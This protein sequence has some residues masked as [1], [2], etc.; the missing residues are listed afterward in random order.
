MKIKYIFGYIKIAYILICTILLFSISYKVSAQGLLFQANDKLISERTSYNVFNSSTPVFNN[1]FTLSFELSI[2]DST[3]FGYICFIKDKESDASFSLTLAETDRDVFLDFNID[4]KQNLLRVPIKKTDLGYRRW[5]LVII[6]F[7]SDK[8]TIEIKFDDK[9][10][11]SHFKQYKNRFS[12]VI[13]F[14]KHDNVIDVPKIAIRKL[15][16]EGDK[17][18]FTFNLDEHDGVDVHDI[19]GDLYGKVENPIWLINDSYHWKLRYTY[20]ALSVAAL[21]FDTR[22]QQI[23]IINTDSIVFF[24]CKSNISKSL[25]YNNELK[26]P[27]KL[28]MS[29]MDTASNSVYV[30]EVNNLP[31]NT[32]TIASLDLNKLI[33]KENSQL[34][35][36]QQRHHHNG[37]FRPDN[38]S[39]IIFGGFGNRKYSN[40]FNEYDITSDKWNLINYKGDAVTPRFFSGQAIEDKNN[41]L[42]FGGVGN[43]TGDQG[44]G[45]TYYFDCYRINHLNHAIKKL[46]NTAMAG[47]G[48]V[49]V[50]N[51]IL[52]DDKQSFY[53]ICYPEY[54]P[55]TFLKLYQFNLFD[56]KYEILGDSIAMN[57]ERIETNAN[58]YLNSITN[59]LYCTTQEFQPDGTSVIRVYSLS[60]PPVSGKLFISR[61]FA[62][63]NSWILYFVFLI[64][65]VGVGISFLLLRKKY[66][67]K[68]NLLSDL[69]I[70]EPVNS[71]TDSISYPKKNNAMYMFGDFK[72]FDKNSRDITH[73]FSPKIKQ[74]FLFILLDYARNGEGVTSPQIYLNI[75]PDKPTDKAKN[76]KGVTQNQL[77]HILTDIEGIQ[78]INNKGHHLLETDELFYCDYFEYQNILKDVVSDKENNE[79][80][81][82]LVNILSK[83]PFL[84]SINFECFDTYKK[85]F[86]DKVLT[87]LQP[88]IETYFKNAN[89]LK[90]IQMAQ[91]LNSIDEQNDDVLHY[92][93]VSYINLNKLDLAK[94]R[95]NS[96]LLSYKRENNSGFP[97]SFQELTNKRNL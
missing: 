14:G 92:E 80:L 3:S 34:Q 41:A 60:E 90:A 57:S 89:Y 42:L 19:K 56:G 43:K 11:S 13:F 61:Q 10:Y 49:S 35:L 5:H 32:N 87:I 53:T 37:F 78:L 86:D 2:I 83:G 63:S 68:K 74:L 72:A 84:K 69:V 17:K 71:H 1:R 95:Y 70:S 50:R 44:L 36:E 29:F 18:S 9:V 94:K 28:G 82:K 58:L 4:S 66:R 65:F 62:D 45:K 6:S 48:L 79:T 40:E 47:E 27:M 23:I 75:W 67:D 20:K 7:L 59:E 38:R 25:K 54:I 52:S 30:Y 77:M 26:V 46:W 88:L 81:Q 76:S 8:N 91:I 51:M 85:D 12:P 97:L 33:W 22:Q 21:N 31:Q 93:I 55:N 39:Y 73:L 96:Y 24:D 64:V 15:I 16:I